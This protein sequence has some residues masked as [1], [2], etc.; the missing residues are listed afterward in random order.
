VS[1]E[2]AFVYDEAL[3]AYSFGEDHPFHPLRVR[4]TIELCESLGLLE[5]YQFAGPSPATDEDLTRVHY[6]SYV[7]RVKKASRG[8]DELEEDD[9][10]ELEIYGLGTEDNPIFKGMHEASAH[11]AGA[12]IE[13]CQLVMNGEVEHALSLAGGLHHAQEWQASGFCIYNDLGIAIARLKEEHPGI[14]IAY[15]DTDVHHGDGIQWMF[16]EDPDVLTVSMHET[17]RRVFPG[18]GAVRE[19]GQREGHG[20]SVNLPLEP[21]TQDDSF[22]ECFECLVPEVFRSFGPDLIISQNGCDAHALDFLADL[23]VTTRVYEHVPRRVHE[24][25]HELCDGRWVATGGGGY[26]RWRVVP[27]AWAALWATV[28][29]Q[30]LPDEMPED[31]LEKWSQESPVELPRYTRDDPEDYPSRKSTSEIA[32]RNRQTVEKLLEKIRE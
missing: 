17:G 13:A 22:I 3:E 11:V 14:R 21:R 6:T 12:T 2:A 23:E 24:L 26:E 30:E 5:G 4:L 9:L 16:Y 19:R 20:Y 1:G 28:S 15:V 10:E 31:W 25:A 18:T 32:D 8:K 7:R 27:R 29:H